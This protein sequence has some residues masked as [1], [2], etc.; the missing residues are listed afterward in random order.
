MGQRFSVSQISGLES[1]LSTMESRLNG[2]AGTN[3]NDTSCVKVGQYVYAALRGDFLCNCAVSCFGFSCCCHIFLG[4]C[5]L[6]CNLIPNGFALGGSGTTGIQS[7]TLCNSALSQGCGMCLA[8]ASCCTCCYARCNFSL[9]TTTVYA[10]YGA[11]TIVQSGGWG[12]TLWRR[13]C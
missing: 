12:S 4:E 3:A 7:P 5:V 1:R 10:A 8:I 2:I 9:G 13:V 6:G 11:V